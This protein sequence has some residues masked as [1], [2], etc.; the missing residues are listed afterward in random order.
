MC[1][2]SLVESV[3]FSYRS[4]EKKFDSFPRVNS[5]ETTQVPI[6]MVRERSGALM[7]PR[8]PGAV[9]LTLGFKSMRSHPVPSLRC[10]CENT[11]KYFILASFSASW[12]HLSDGCHLTHDYGITVLHY[13]YI[14]LVHLVLSGTIHATNLVYNM[15]VIQ[16]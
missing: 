5:V 4:N 1:V 3:Q 8:G 16:T 2:V 6:V 14:Q 11:I 15:C 7:S 9:A 13:T 12:C 10:G